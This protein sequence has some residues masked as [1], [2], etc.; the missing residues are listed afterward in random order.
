MEYKIGDFSRIS[1]VTVR[2]LRYYDE[3]G[4]I[5][6]VRVDELTGYRYYSIEQLPQLNRIIML[7]EIGLSLDDI[8]STLDSGA[9][10]GHIRQLL[11]VKKSEIQERLNLDTRRLRQVEIWLDRIDQEGV[12]PAGI[13]IQRKTVPEVRIISKRE[14]GTYEETTLKLYK[15]IMDYIDSFGNEE[16]AMITG[17]VTGLFYDD[18]Y[19]ETD[20]DIEVAVPISGDIPVDE[21]G[22][23]VKTLPEIDVISV[24][25]KGPSY[26]IHRTYAQIIEYAEV[27]KLKLD[28][29]LR[30]IYLTYP[31]LDP[32]EGLPIEIQCP[33]IELQV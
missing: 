25:Y 21:T 1:R 12:I 24:V 23:E 8:G 16:T 19:K 10:V 31:E 20:A 29:P 33:F 32:D 28:T 6:P 17:P 5:K 9:P 2:T 22:F 30:E 15:E 3:I 18:E 7:K 14:M 27:H 26:D 4:L 11:Q 13:Y